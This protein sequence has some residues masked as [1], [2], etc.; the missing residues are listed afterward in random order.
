MLLTIES[1]NSSLAAA[2]EDIVPSWWFKSYYYDSFTQYFT[3]ANMG[4]RSV[5]EEIPED[6][7]AWIL[8][9]QLAY[10][11]LMH[12]NEIVSAVMIICCGRQPRLTCVN[13]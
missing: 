8:D 9:N 10:F 3:A 7:T 1:F 5:E 4:R 11:V 2:A 13:R 12:T 6:P